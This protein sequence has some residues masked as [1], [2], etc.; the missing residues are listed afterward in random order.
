[1]LDYNRIIESGN[2]VYKSLPQDVRLREWRV[3]QTTCRVKYYKTVSLSSLETI[4]LRL[5]KSLEGKLITKEEF[6]LIL[7]FDIA[8]R[9]FG[10]K[11]YYKDVS[12]VQLYQSMISSLFEWNLII[13]EPA[14]NESAEGKDTEQST[15]DVDK[16]KYLRLTKLG[17]IALERNCKFSFFTG[18]KILIEN[19]NK[20]ILE[21]DTTFFPFYSDLG[22]Y[23][24]I[25]LV[26]P[27]DK[28]NADTIN[29]EY[30]DDL[31]KRLDLQSKE[32]SNIFE[33][34]RLSEWKYTKY[35]VDLNVYKYEGA[36][37]PI[38]FS[39]N[40]LSEKAS[41]IFY[42]DENLLLRN[43]K[44][45]KALYYKLINQTDS[46]INY[47]EIKFFEDEIEQDEFDL[48]IKD[49]RTDWSDDATYSFIVGNELCKEMQWQIISDRCPIDVIISH[50]TNADS[51][52]DFIILSR[53]L[54]ISFIIENSSKYHWDMDIVMSRE[55][56]TKQQA[57]TLMVSEVNSDIEWD[58]DLT[59]SFLDLD[60]VLNNI[61]DLNIDYY[62]LTKWLPNSNLS[63]LVE[64]PDRK[65]NWLVFAT[66]ADLDLIISKINILE[67]HIKIYV[68]TILDRIFKNSEFINQAIINEEFTNTLR[69][70]QDDG[71]L[72][73]YNL[74]FKEDY[75]WD[76]QLIDY[77][78]SCNILIWNSDEF[79]K[80]FAQ[81]SYI[82]WS[83]E[84][85]DRYHH[86]IFNTD[87]LSYISKSIDSLQFV[88]DYPNF[89]WDWNALSGNRHLASNE[90]FLDL[91]KE[92][93]D[94]ET[95]LNNSGITFS[96]DFFISHM[97]WMTSLDNSSFVSKNIG[98]FD[99]VIK[100]DS[101]PW[102]WTSLAQNESIINDEL[103]CQRLG[104]HPD[105]I[106]NW[107]NKANSEMI[108]KYYIELR[109]PDYINNQIS[110]DQ[111]SFYSFDN[112]WYELSNSL[113]PEFISQNLSDNW[114]KEIISK[115]IN[116]ILE[117]DPS[118]LSAYRDL[119]DW[120]ILSNQL[121]IDF[122]QENISEY[123][124][125]W[126]WTILTSRL[127]TEFI[128][129]NFSSY[130]HYWNQE[131]IQDKIIPLL[132]VD[133][134]LNQNLSTY[135][136]W[137]IVSQKLPDETLSRVLGQIPDFLDWDTISRRI[138]ESDILRID[139]ILAK[140][141]NI[142]DYLLW[143]ILSR[144]MPLSSILSNRDIVSSKWNWTIITHR[145]D[146]EF[147]INNLST[148]ADYWDW[149]VVLKQKFN[150]TFLK[151]NLERIKDSLLNLPSDKKQKCWQTI[152][153]VYSP[154]KLLEIS[155][156]Y[157]PL[158]G[159]EWDYNYAYLAI[160]DP[161]DFVRSTHTYIDWTAFSACNAVDH[162]F[163]YNS[164]IYT[165]RA[166]KTI[167][168]NKLNDIVF[169]WDYSVLTRLDSIQQKHEVFYAISPEQW[170][171]DYISQYGRCLL[172][173]NNRDKYIKKYRDRLNFGLI[174]LREDIE[175]DDK[176]VDSFIDKPWDWKALS[177]NENTRLSFGF[178]CRLKE[179][180]WDW[181]AL[182]KNSSIKWDN[183]NLRLLINDS[184]IR[185]EISWDDIVAKQEI[186]FD[187]NILASMKKVSYSWYTLTGN[188]S[189]HPSQKTISQAIESGE[190]LNWDVLSNNK[191]IDLN[192]VREYKSY[193]NWQILTRNASV[194]DINKLDIVDEFED[195]LDWSYISEKLILSSSILVRFKEELDWNIVNRRFDYNELDLSVVHDIKDFVDWTKLSAASVVFTEKF[196]KQYCSKIDW[197]AI[198]RN[199]SIDLT[200]DIFNDFSQE[201]NRVRF[202]DNL[203]C[204]G[205]SY[206]P[207]KV[208]HFS[209]MFNAIGIIKS[210]KIL[211]RNKAESMKQ[212]K[213][214]A[215]G[216]VVHRTSKAH[217]YARFYFRPK[218]PTQFYNECLGWD[219]TLQTHWNKSYYPQACNLHLPKCPMP[220]FFEFDIRE[221][222]AK[223]PE[224]CF[225]STGNLQTN[226]AT[227]L[228]V[229]N[230]PG[231]IRTE[232]LY[233]DMSDA[234]DMARSGYEYD[235]SSH[236]MYLNL[237]KEQSQ[238]EFLILDEFD[239]S[240][241]ESI[242]IY[243]YD[244]EQKK[245]LTQYLGDDE[246]VSKIYVGHNLYS[247]NNRYLKIDEDNRSITITS[248]YDI[249]GCAYLL[250]KGGEILNKK[251]IRNTTASGVIIY[252]SVCFKKDNPP[253][254]IYFVDPNPM[255]DTKEWLIFSST[256]E[257]RIPKEQTKYILDDL[258]RNS[259]D[260]F[261]PEMESLPIML[262]KALFYKHM[263]NSYHGIAHTAR[264]LFATHLLVNAI[265]L[266][267][268]ERKAC[269]IA[270]IIHDLGKR[271]DIEGKEHGYNS[272]TLYKNRIA[273]L[274]EDSSLADRVLK[275]VE[276][277]SVEDEDCPSEVKSDIIWK[278]LKDADAL[279]R[280]RF[281]GKGCDK[282]YL[283][284][285]I[286]KG[287]DGMIILGLT[288]YLPA[289]TKDLLWDNPYQ[290][291]INQIK[292]FS[293]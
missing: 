235:R 26:S 40:A 174:S 285:E 121:S 24:E 69:K 179:K 162:M 63:L 192:F 136:D 134:V 74:S 189:Y 29:I 180:P 52:F 265:D 257:L 144:D 128:H 82:K 205:G 279:D 92:R 190:E 165:F 289:W 200:A 114:N 242:K 187:D 233:K 177:S 68:E 163:E 27:L 175:I 227:V 12:E 90:Q 263:V 256:D 95:W 232:Y 207:F 169:N 4:F 70:Y 113:S 9:K 245:L 281:R 102:N 103:F 49:K 148:Y 107:I 115:R 123:R 42:R 164:D 18:S 168:K 58:W 46:V 1:M 80:G 53:R 119:F 185:E 20:S 262:S 59:K 198:S 236:M 23:T 112:L 33:A 193:F 271:S 77:L 147:L 28:Y 88:I 138:S 260:T 166:W 10:I 133:E 142:S 167:I 126:D 25:T 87:D 223:M 38:V 277:H 234:Y 6:G 273:N 248:N 284:L 275:A 218:S 181:T 85:F 132:N 155:E 267:Q 110:S 225:Y 215:A 251:S 287:K 94:Y 288:S 171:W 149:N 54:P 220:V 258:V 89:K 141:T 159:Y 34:Q 129:D 135:W 96:D 211:S 3:M 173:E 268:D 122:I 100:Y 101:F 8:N 17:Q 161:E 238:Q 36:F 276:Y 81:Y 11:R 222:I 93:V 247:Y 48:I 293:E 86:K 212:L 111:S 270:A 264:V 170:D 191:Y 206:R 57:Q 97:Q 229:D 154:E 79:K 156:S 104:M 91:G 172:V 153:K 152:S 216:S 139:D 237:I 194:I 226:F 47:D 5:L 143:D 106:P 125:L 56:I 116:P 292:K 72:I 230:E 178:I 13:E 64:Y 253:K 19:I 188:P 259:I 15:N 266:D 176:L 131:L 240:D 30:K 62:N 246:L 14:K 243:C 67:D 208:Y 61:R 84:F 44:V 219:D 66:N 76:Y 286:Y 99:Y 183:K 45:K 118:I 291:L 16:K 60:F 186:S 124:E 78:E 213:Y 195:T 71:A 137:Q 151:D 32:E 203:N 290:E 204:Y 150:Q 274:I 145:F 31:I 7:G 241:I 228:K 43:Y 210:R 221:I 272:M 199:E 196:L 283:R 182:S 146:N 280:S 130:S 249:D 202:I 282:S 157:S 35:D 105:A 252:P 83:R 244:D 217:P 65:W 2:L 231:R 37:Y 109:I 120:K 22:I 117:K 214:D 250:V 51:R 261:I 184:E 75:L 21:E 39:N 73:S 127:T 255:A 158:N 197:S 108:E 55:D 140:N 50:L 41:D 254:E 160:M 239:F 224:K 269:Y 209:H 98:S 278:I 201:L